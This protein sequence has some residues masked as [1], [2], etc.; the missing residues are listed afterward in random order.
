[1]AGSGCQRPSRFW[2]L[3]C[4]KIYHEAEDTLAS[5]GCP[6]SRR[7]ARGR[8][9]APPSRSEQGHHPQ[10]Q[11]NEAHGE[12]YHGDLMRRPVPYVRMAPEM[13]EHIQRGCP[14]HQQV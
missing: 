2:G 9:A 1:M 5:R 12:G 6:A 10:P 14:F 13:P 3:G 11:T 8:I 4:P 7:N